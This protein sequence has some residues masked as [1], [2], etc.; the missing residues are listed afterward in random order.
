MVIVVENGHDEPSSNPGGVCIS[1]SADIFG[2]G[3]NAIILPP[4]IDI[5]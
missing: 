2:K 4:S 3:M 5:S 1:N